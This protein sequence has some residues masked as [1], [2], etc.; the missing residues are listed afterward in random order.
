MNTTIRA[1]I[2]T[3][4]TGALLIGSFSVGVLIQ[5][6]QTSLAGASG[7]YLCQIGPQPNDPDAQEQ[8]SWSRYTSFDDANYRA[9]IRCYC[10]PLSGKIVGVANTHAM[11]DCEETWKHINFRLQFVRRKHE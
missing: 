5:G 3:A 1:F 9:Y 11:G 10:D 4:F 2:V 6:V 7:T 8:I